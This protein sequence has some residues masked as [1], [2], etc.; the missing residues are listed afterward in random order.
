MLIPI[1]GSSPTVLNTDQDAVRRLILGELGRVGLEWRSL[2]QTDY[3]ASFPLR[4]VITLARH[5]AG[6]VVLG[7]SQFE[8]NRGIRKKGTPFEERVNKRIVFPT[9][10]NQ[11]EAGVLFALGKPVLVFRESGILGGIF[12][13]GVAD[14]FVQ[15]MPESTVK[16][17]QRKAFR[18]VLQK[19]A[20]QVQQ[21]YHSV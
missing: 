21:H 2:G 1:F 5:C 17:K 7:F 15:S 13:N 6:G 20:A 18:E 9:A 8:A 3:P 4:E 11:L 19:F 12:D 14:V 10:W 16:G